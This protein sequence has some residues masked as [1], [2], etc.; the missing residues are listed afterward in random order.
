MNIG[1]LGSGAV[2]QTIG[3]KLVELGHDVMLVRV[4]RLT[5]GRWPGQMK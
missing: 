4:I 2:G 5:P 3:S 1:V